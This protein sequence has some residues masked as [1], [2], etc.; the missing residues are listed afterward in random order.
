[1]YVLLAFHV[2]CQLKGGLLLKNNSPVDIGY[3]FNVYKMSVRR[4]QHHV[5]VLKTLRRRHVYTGR[6]IA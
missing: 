5:D 1:M 4:S 6:P 3:R 2:E